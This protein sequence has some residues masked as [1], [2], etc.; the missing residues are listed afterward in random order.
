MPG[1][2]VEALQVDRVEVGR[3]YPHDAG[4]TVGLVLSQ[5]DRPGQ[6]TLSLVDDVAFATA[7]LILQTLDISPSD[8][9]D[10]W[11]ADAAGPESETP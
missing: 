1:R 4:P 6:L 9:P 11:P 5:A 7:C 3:V 10:E 2:D 8:L